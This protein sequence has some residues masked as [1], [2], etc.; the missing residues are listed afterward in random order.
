LLALLV[1]LHCIIAL[2]SSL[3]LRLLAADTVYICEEKRLDSIRFD[4]NRLDSARPAS[5]PLKRSSQPRQPAMFIGTTAAAARLAVIRRGAAVAGKKYCSAGSVTAVVGR[6]SP[7]LLLSNSVLDARY[8]ASSS[9]GAATAPAAAPAAAA[10]AAAGVSTANEP[11]PPAHAMLSTDKKVLAPPMVYIAGEEMTHYASQLILKEWFEPYFDLS[12]WENYD[13]SCVNRDKTNDQVLKDAV[14]AGKRVGAIFKEPTIT[15]TAVQQEEMKLSQPLGSPNGAMRRGWNGM[16]ISRDTIHIEGIE[17]GY[18]RPVL[19][20]RHAVGGEY[21]AG[22]AQVGKGTLLTTYLPKNGDPP[23]VVDK[24]DLKDEHSVCVVY[25]NPY[26]N[27]RDL[28]HFFF[29]RCL[30]QNV[31]PYVVT[32]KTV[33]KWQEGFW[34][35]MKEVFDADYKQKFIDAGLTEKSGGELS[36]LISDAATMQLVRWTK[37]G[38]G[39][40]AHNYDG[41]MRKLL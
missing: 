37:G 9:I 13:L 19:F 22:W 17:L 36:H 7:A 29:Q 14:E 8:F 5:Q 32:K 3:T 23:F 10:T 30:D 40:A 28:A 38:F 31:T 6:S 39:M 18:K 34:T 26:D 2:L 20:E 16:T 12:Q 21:S 11:K 25:D 4:W 41:D 27:V 33:F 35:T 15:P 24:R 1:V